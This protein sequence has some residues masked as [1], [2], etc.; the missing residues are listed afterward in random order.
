VGQEVVIVRHGET[1]WSREGRHTGRTDVP[2]SDEGRAQAQKLRKTFGGH[3]FAAVFSSPLQRAHDT[4]R[5]A[6]FDSKVVLD[7]DLQEWDY[8]EYDGMTSA[9]V[10]ARRPGWVLWRDGCIGGESLEQVARRADRVIE[11]FRAV[12]G[13]VLAFAHG[14]ILRVVTA[15]WIDMHAGAGQRFMLLPASPSTLG[16]EHDWTALRAWNLPRE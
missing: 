2:L 1:E 7:P 4:A 5:L 13:D 14:H 3:A 10:I 15:R 6:G 12:E 16:Y 11:R 8:G 9:E